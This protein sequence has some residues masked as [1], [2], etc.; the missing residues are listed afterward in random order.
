M[1][2]RMEDLAREVTVVPLPSLE[3][4]AAAQQS[5]AG[6]ARSGVAMAM[7]YGTPPGRQSG[8]YSAS[9]VARVQQRLGMWR[10]HITPDEVRL[11]VPGGW[12]GPWLQVLV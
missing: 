10:W 5:L 8:G 4:A 9:L 7:M 6:G 2:R 12:T 11:S 3:E 1:L